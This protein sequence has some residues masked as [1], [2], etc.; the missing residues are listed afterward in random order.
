MVIY[1]NAAGTINCT[2]I[3]WGEF[4]PGESKLHTVYARNLNSFDISLTLQTSGWD[5]ANATDYIGLSWNNTAVVLSPYTT[6]VLAVN[7]TVFANVTGFNSFAFNIT[8]S[9]VQSG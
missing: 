8:V 9:G 1:E 4:Q 5:P 2:S 6:R 7:C 3:D